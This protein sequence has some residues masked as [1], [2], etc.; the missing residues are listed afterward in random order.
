MFLKRGAGE[1]IYT[2]FCLCMHL[3]EAQKKLKHWLPVGMA[4][5]AGT[6]HM[7]DHNWR[8]IFYKSSHILD[9]FDCRNVVPR[10]FSFLLLLLLSKQRRDVAFI[11][12][13]ES[14]LWLQG[15]GWAGGRQSEAGIAVRKKRRGAP[16]HSE[17]RSANISWDC[18]NPGTAGN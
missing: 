12:S 7:A 2:H 17:K 8:K 16:P 9:S 10:W 14:S 11:C 4:L 1:R 3:K 15:R 18:L 13:L 6:R 5:G